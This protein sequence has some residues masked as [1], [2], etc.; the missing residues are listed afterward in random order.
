MKYLIA[1]ASLLLTACATPVISATPDGSIK[2][3]PDASLAKA[4][5]ER[6]ESIRLLQLRL[7][8]NGYY[9]GPIDGIM[10]PEL[11]KAAKGE[12]RDRL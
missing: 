8:E 1:T 10:S 5:A 3:V 12:L 2:P 11:R 6:A 7:S 4:E 9:A